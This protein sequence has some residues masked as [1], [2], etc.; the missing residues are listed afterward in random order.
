MRPILTDNMHRDTN[1]DII[2]PMNRGLS[3]AI[4][5]KSLTEYLEF[6]V[7]TAYLAGRMTM[8]YY[9]VGIQPETKS[10][11]S[12]VTI[13][14]R[15]SE[16][17]IRSRIEYRYPTHAIIGEEYGALREGS[18]LR[19]FIDPI[20]GTKSFL[21]GVP[22][23]AVL[24]GLEIEGQ[25]DVGVAYFPALDEMLSAA[26][27]L[28]CWWN[29][30]RAYVSNLPSLD[31]AVFTTTSAYNFEKFGCKEIFDRLARH[32]YF[33]AGW[34]DAYGYMLVATGRAELMVDPVMNAWDCAPF[35]PILS[36]AGGFFGDWQGRR[37]IDA[38]QALAT[39]SILLPEVLAL[40]HAS[41]I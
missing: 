6:A 38:G 3:A 13:A 22:L 17:L 35:P 21:H 11:Q 27:G 28:G 32:C 40:M 18:S 41:D 34:G 36:E 19:W 39:S 29:G 24:I 33:Q 2:L 16:E 1:H 15:K 23:F 14:D 7:E 5:T 25:V 30:R 31:Q 37:V 12:P 20:D 9:Q 26:T 4:S 8:G 10:D